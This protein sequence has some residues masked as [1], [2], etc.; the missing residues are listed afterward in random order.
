MSPFSL[1]IEIYHMA[2]VFLRVGTLVMLLPAIGDRAV[3]VQIRLAFALMLTMCL[4][5]TALPVLPPT[6]P[7]TLGEMGGQVFKELF[8]GLALGALLQ[9]MMTALA[10]AG[11]I[12]S[13]QTTLAFAQTANPVEAQPGAT[14]STFL[15]VVAMALIFATNLDHLFIGA[16]AHSYHMFPPMK[17]IQVQDMGLEAVRAV[18]EAFSLGIQLSAPVIVFSL[19]FNVA[20]GLIGRLIPQFQIFFAVAPLTVLLGLSVFMLSIGLI[21]VVWLNRYQEFLVQFT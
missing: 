6:M 16:I 5:S 4:Q 19:V 17:P 9:F 7:Q 1:P 21:G 20:A 15:S 12:I 3:P 11:E 10:V 2:L 18:A 8:V 14:L 13:I